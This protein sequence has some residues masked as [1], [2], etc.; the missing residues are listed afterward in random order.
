[1]T[2]IGFSATRASAEEGFE[3]AS[4]PEIRTAA[5]S[6]TTGKADVTKKGILLFFLNP[7]GRPCQMQAQILQE[8]ITE[9]EKYV[10][11]QAL[12]TQISD[13]RAYFYQFGIRQLPSLVLL[14]ADGNVVHRFS[15][16][17]HPGE[18]LLPAIQQLG[19]Q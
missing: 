7:N 14:G 8:N 1:V 5:E 4:M 13:H 17:I 15:P 19:K 12:S 10:R 2:V 9:I 11:I 16:G 18:S 6:A 3:T